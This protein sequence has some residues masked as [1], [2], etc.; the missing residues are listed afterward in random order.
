MMK[1]KD[2]IAV[3]EGKH[4]DFK[5]DSISLLF[6]ASSI[7]LFTF[8]MNI[9]FNSTKPCSIC[10]KENQNKKLKINIKTKDSGLSDAIAGF[11]C[12]TLIKTIQQ[13]K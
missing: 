6:F 4:T 3:H 11:H 8:L 5:A 7:I 12:H 10:G 2:E 9:F 13:I 1:K